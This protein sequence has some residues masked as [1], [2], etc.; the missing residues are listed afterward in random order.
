MG[1]IILKSDTYAIFELERQLQTGSQPTSQGVGQPTYQPPMAWP[2]I[3][4]PRQLG[5]KII[6]I[7]NYLQLWPEV[8]KMYNYRNEMYVCMYMSEWKV[9]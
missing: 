6:K 1:I 7:K 2:I 4:P 8:S 5:W 3:P 9:E